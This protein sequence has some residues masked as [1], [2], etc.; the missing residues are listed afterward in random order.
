VIPGVWSRA[1]RGALRERCGFTLL[2][3]LIVCALMAIMLAF[4]IPAYQSYLKRVYRT[5]ALEVLLAAAACEER[6]HAR[7]F[8]Y[9]TNRCLPQPGEGDAYAFGFEPGQ[10]A[11]ASA[12]VAIA[13][14][15]GPQSADPCGSLML[16]QDGTRSI[17]GPPER[18]RKCWEGR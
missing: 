3:L 2:E 9:D 7:D 13:S 4:A 14:P 12:Y 5:T 18:L 17:S 11:A 16:D 6:I 15:V 8:S 10:T 1:I